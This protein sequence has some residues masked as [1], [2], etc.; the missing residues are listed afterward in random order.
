MGVNWNPVYDAWNLRETRMTYETPLL[1]SSYESCAA[2]RSFL[3]KAGY[4]EANV[5]KFLGIER[6]CDFEQVDF[7]RLPAEEVEPTPLGLL[8][9]VFF[10]LQ[11]A[12]VAEIESAIP[13]DVVKTMQALDLLRRSED[14]KP[15]FYSSVWLYPAEDLVLASDRAKDLQD[16]VFPAIS[17][18][19]FRFLKRMSRSPA[20]AALDLCSGSGVAAL[21]LSQH[22][23]QVIASDVSPRAVHFAKFNCLLNGRDHVTAVESDLYS[24]LQGKTFDRIV[25][26]PPYVPSLSNAVIWRDGGATGEEPLR[27]IVEGLP[28]FLRRGGTFYASCGGFDTIEHKF[29]HRIRDWLGPAH[30]QFDVLFAV[31]FDK[32]PWDLAVASSSRPEVDPGGQRLLERFTEMRAQNFAAGSL[33]IYRRTESESRPPVQA[34][35]QRTQLSPM[36]DGS[37]LDAYLLWWRWLSS[38]E[39]PAALGHLKPRL[40]ASLRVKI[41]HVVVEHELV[42]CSIVLESSR[43]FQAETKVEPE[44]VQVLLRCDGETSLLELHG[45]ARQASWVPENLTLPDFLKFSARMI[46]RGYLEVD[47][48]ALDPN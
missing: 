31:E 26:H 18:L 27:H 1:L 3:E 46:E 10:L 12:P 32:S 23:P 20:T 44:M 38:T 47:A 28:A 5:C 15:Q 40:G 6:I 21:L 45:I 36:T 42:P 39:S 30:G 2:T 22:C 35:T 19:S 41:D 11:E 24:A 14:G 13:E 37:C 29:E 17:P 34:L 7:G 4:N 16:A 43:P 8:I 25:A 48:S 33:L 9:R